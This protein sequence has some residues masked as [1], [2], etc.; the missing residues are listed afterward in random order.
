MCEKWNS[1]SFLCFCFFIL[2]LFCMNRTSCQWKFK[3]TGKSPDFSPKYCAQKRCPLCKAIFDAISTFTKP[4]EFLKDI[5]GPNKY[6]F[7]DV[8]LELSFIQ[9]LQ[10]DRTVFY[11]QFF[12]KKPQKCLNRKFLDYSTKNFC[13]FQH[14]WG[15]Q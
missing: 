6:R 14:L 1:T 8:A 10:Q 3:K 2:R 7:L 5:V 13:L 9:V 15:I 12:I 11:L 4:L